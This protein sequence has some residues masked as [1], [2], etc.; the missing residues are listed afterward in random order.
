MIDRTLARGL[1]LGAIALAFG[2]TAARYQIGSFNHAGPGLFPLM[3]SGAL[4]LIA[5]LTIV[6]SRFEPAEP[7]ELRVRNIG[8]L[9]LSLSAFAGVSL[10]VNMT[11][12][13]VSMVFIAA[14]AGKTYSWSRNLKVS[15]GL[16]LVAVAFR[17]GLG[18]NLPLY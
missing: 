16:V 6:R 3:M 14:L 4:G 15:L 1:F 8:L 13:I 17:Q 2:V 11:A 18:L 7:L 5:L 9:L 10:W 12:G